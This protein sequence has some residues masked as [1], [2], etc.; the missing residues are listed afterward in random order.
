MDPEPGL[1]RAAGAAA[2]RQATS[3]QTPEVTAGGTAEKCQVERR[4][5]AAPDAPATQRAFPATSRDHL[6]WGRSPRKASYPVTTHP[7]PCAG[8]DADAQSSPQNTTEVSVVRIAD[9][10][11]EYWVHCPP[12]PPAHSDTQH[13][14]GCR[15]CFRD[16]SRGLSP[17][18]LPTHTH[19]TP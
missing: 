14:A 12:W 18:S 2:P 6:P 8:R 4:Q 5:Q 15:D 3:V 19:T 17:C 1:G 16:A 11:F 7:H 9:V 10:K 13:R